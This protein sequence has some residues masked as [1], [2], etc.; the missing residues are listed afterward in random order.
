MSLERVNMTQK[1]N[2]THKEVC[3][4]LWTKRKNT[5]IVCLTTGETYLSANEAERKTGIWGTS[6]L[7]CCDGKK[8]TAGKKE[9]AYV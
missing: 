8:R 7:N 5:P 9:W 2:I 3:F 6:I 4:N 1:E